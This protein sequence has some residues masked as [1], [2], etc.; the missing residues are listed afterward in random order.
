[1]RSL[2][3]VIAI[4]MIA[5]G[6][7]CG[8]VQAAARGT[9]TERDQMKVLNNM[10]VELLNRRAL[11]ARERQELGFTNPY[12]GW[13]FFQ[14]TAKTTAKD[15]VSVS[16]DGAPRDKAIIIHSGK[17]GRVV[18][19][20]RCLPK[21]KHSISIW[22]EG[23]PSLEA[24][25]VR[26]IPEL[27]YC[28]YPRGPFIEKYGAYDWKFLEKYVFP[29]ANCMTADESILAGHMPEI[30]AWK[31]Q[32]KR[33]VFH[34]SVPGAAAGSPLSVDEAYK[35]WHEQPGFQQPLI[36][37]IIVDEF[38]FPVT[39]P[40]YKIWA[41]AIDKIYQDDKLKDK[42]FY[43][44]TFG[45]PMSR[46]EEGKAFVDALARHGGKVAPE[47]YIAE[48]PTAEEADKTCRWIANQAAEYRKI[49]PD[50]GRYIILTLGYMSQPTESL[51][52]DPTVDF[53]V[54]LDRQMYMIANDPA[55]SKQYGLMYY[56]SP[57]T[58]E[59]TVRWGSRLFRHYCIE[60]K[61]TLL[62]DEL[63]YTYNLNHIQN[64]DFEDG[65]NGWT[66]SEAEADGI[67]PGH[68]KG[69][70]WLEGRYPE[71]HLGDKFLLTKRS[72]TKPNA[73]SQKIVNLK[74]GR[75]YSMKMFTGDYQAILSGK[76][77]K[78]DALAMSIKIDNVDLVAGRCFDQVIDNNYSHHLGKFDDV[79]KAWMIYHWRVFRAKGT[80]AMLTITDWESETKPGGPVGQ[81][82]MHNF[83]EIQPYYLD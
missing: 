39:D 70:S 3:V 34:A 82:L 2:A 51:N 66:V 62:S 83:I 18:E 46:G 36:D 11:V 19:A 35:Y 75:L 52:I 76:C 71:T 60:G 57:Y 69:W 53:K 55:C 77:P 30:K 27:I 81:E 44:W 6:A 40:R 12:D 29:N 1:M 4:W 73:F 72:A 13:V 8:S 54:F 9:E 26:A 42:V 23:K 80:T 56:L 10:V 45:Y 15:R 79:N 63:G 20:M 64:P 58:D 14:T 28:Q 47:Y 33:W 78:F 38:G 25:V 74:P 41:E 16:I 67:T 65:L 22:C 37:G 48:R 32:G 61:K 21:G 7:L 31:E 50:S 59:E 68:L 5:I 43:A 17:G 49:D 24:V